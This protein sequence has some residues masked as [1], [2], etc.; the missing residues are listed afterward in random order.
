LFVHGAWS[1]RT[2]GRAASV[3]LHNDPGGKTK[4]PFENKRL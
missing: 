3:N 4:I 2:S 1:G